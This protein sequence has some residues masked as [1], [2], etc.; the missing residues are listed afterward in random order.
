YSSR[1]CPFQCSF[2]SETIQWGKFRK[3]KPEQV[4]N[5]LEAL[6]KKHKR[7]LFLLGDSLL[8][9]VITDLARLLNHHEKSFYWDGYL[10]V[11]AAAC[12]RENTQLWR[13]GGF[14][15]ARLGVESGSQ[16]VLEMMHKEITPGQIRDSLYALAYAGIKTTTYW[17]VGHPG[18]T[19][20]HFQQT[21]DLL[22][23]AKDNIYEAWCSPFYYYRTSQVNSGNWGENSR[24]LYPENAKDM[25]IA[26]TWYL[27]TEPSREV[28]YQRMNRFVT[29]CNRLNIPNPYSL[30]DFLK[31]DERWKKLHKN[32]VPS[33]GE[34]ENVDSYI[35]ENKHVKE[36]RDASK[37]RKDD[38]VFN[39]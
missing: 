11:G 9:P 34:F 17:V 13:R 25:L 33:I 12:D 28:A 26:Q 36:K 27:A 3:K 35:D 37:T 23:Q 21:L 8:N 31:A 32:A 24:L 6:Y 29:H 19:E 5:E 2:C 20:E 30:A 16:Q 15:R 10:R 22:E 1:S 7:Q 4:V 39:F 18:E 38:I 14:Y